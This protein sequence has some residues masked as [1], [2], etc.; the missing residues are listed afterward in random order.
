MPSNIEIKAR[1]SDPVRTRELAR[2]IATEGSVEIDQDDTFF[3][4]PSG[5]LKLRQFSD[6]GG[7]LIFYQRP[8]V[9]GP[10]QSNYLISPID[11]PD[12]VRNA[13][14]A[15]LGQIGR[16]KKHRTLYMHG[17]TRIH[18]DVVENL[19][20]FLELEVVMHDGEHCEAG[21]AEANMLIKLLEIHPEEMIDGAYLDLMQRKNRR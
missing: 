14:T 10:K 15:A 3:N 12:L 21:E 20:D 6:G 2:S 7:E 13:L 19:G 9:A 11:K 18:L 5:R 16:V 4:C 17:R 1:L 8:D